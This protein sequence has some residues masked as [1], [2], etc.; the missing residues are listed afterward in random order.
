VQPMHACLSARE[1][2]VFYKIAN[3]RSVRAIG[4]E[5]GLSAKSVSTYRTRIMQKMHFLTNAEITTYALR[6]ELIQ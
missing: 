4:N 2:Q 3:G 1:F 6:K 5:L